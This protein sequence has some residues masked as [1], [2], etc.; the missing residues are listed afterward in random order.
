MDLRVNHQH[1]LQRSLERSQQYLEHD[2]ELRRAEPSPEAIA[3]IARC[4]SSLEC[5]AIAC[6]LY[7]DRPCFGE[8]AFSVV[9]GSVRHRKEY[10]H[11]TYAELWGRVQAFASGLRH[12][13]LADTG[14]RVGICG[15]SRVSWVVADL[16]SLYLCAVSVPLP[17]NASPAE[18]AQIVES[19][20]ARCLVVSL[21]Q[22]DVV[23]SLL[24]KLPEVR[25]VV[26]MGYV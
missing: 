25:S 3:R 19:A 14:D 1:L 12:A 9:D 17:I 8:R 10:H 6:E 20:E 5:V 24:P 22:L 2:A 13:G 21:E 23:A 26:V 15:F 11:I 18:L 16:A 4:K 7:A